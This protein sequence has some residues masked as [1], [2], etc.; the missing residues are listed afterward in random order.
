[1]YNKPTKQNVTT[2]MYIVDSLM[3]VFYMS[4]K[5]RFVRKRPVTILTFVNPF[6]WTMMGFLMP[7]QSRFV[8]ERFFTQ[9]ALES[10]FC[11]K[12]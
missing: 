4:Q 11:S 10:F 9:M 8:D 6:I 12:V 5:G 7:I 2:Y 3:V 1:M